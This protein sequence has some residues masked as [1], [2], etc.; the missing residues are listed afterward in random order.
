MKKHLILI[1]LVLMTVTT[2]AYA[3]ELSDLS[4]LSDNQSELEASSESDDLDE[5]AEN[6]TDTD[7][8]AL[9]DDSS[10][11]E[12][13]EDSGDLGG[14]DNAASEE[15]MVDEQSDVTIQFNGYLKALTYMK[16][17]QYSDDSWDV[18]Q[19]MKSR[20]LKSPEHQDSNYVS[21]VGARFQLRMEGYLGDNAKLFSAVNIDFNDTAKNNTTSETDKSSNNGNLRLVEAFIELYV[22]DSVIKMGPQLMTWG[23]M[24]GF[25]VPTDRVNARDFTYNSTEY[26]D[27]KLPANG[28]LF[29]QPL[30]DT[31]LELLYIPV[32]KTDIQPTH[33][34]YYF[35]GGDDKPEKKIANAKF[36]YRLMD[37]WGNLDWALS[38]VTMVDPQPDLAIDS[39]G[40]FVREYHQ[41]RSPG[42][43]LQY[44]FNSWLAKVAYVEYHTEDKAGENA[45]VKNYWKKYLLGGEFFV[46]GNTINFYAGQTIVDKF[47]A[48]NPYNFLIGQSREMTNFI[49]G[50]ISANFLTG[51]ALNITLLGAGYYDE[52]NVPVQKNLKLTSKYTISNGLDVIVS[53]S[54]FEIA[55][56]RFY[57]L[58][59][60]VKY[61]F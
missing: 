59:A 7:L 4:E 11:E 60:E 23:F 21:D 47:E 25:E 43:D 31:K 30:G 20:G 19:G 32:A 54:F 49:S 46:S 17:N 9:S 44:S 51:N 33:S 37:S 29:Q 35:Q 24:E 26:E 13:T 14:L 3:N 41:V 61:S 56:N 34:D 42:I 27:S 53:P 15:D 1:L 50:H 45:F 40:L 39:K 18:M 28:I 6:D 16:R 10:P 57:N 2:F 52:D 8:D 58:Q 12:L 5:L 38:Y 55:D 36:A 48:E 22:G